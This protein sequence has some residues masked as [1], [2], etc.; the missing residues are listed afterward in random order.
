LSRRCHRSPLPQRLRQNLN[1]LGGLNF[2][3]H[4]TLLHSIE[5]RNGTAASE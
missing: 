2:G 3:D 5:V 4:Y 1:L